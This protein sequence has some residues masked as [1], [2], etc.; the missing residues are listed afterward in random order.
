[1]SEEIKNEG[2]G[3]NH[4]RDITAGGE[5][6]LAFEPIIGCPLPSVSIIDEPYA[7]IWIDIM[8]LLKYLLPA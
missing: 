5:Y 6:K 8:A 2:I 4:V 3:R 7:A 1:M